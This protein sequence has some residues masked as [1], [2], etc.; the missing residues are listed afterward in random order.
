MWPH[1]TQPQDDMIYYKSKGWR[2][3]GGGHGGGGQ[4]D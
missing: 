4:L 1:K 3:G 2:S